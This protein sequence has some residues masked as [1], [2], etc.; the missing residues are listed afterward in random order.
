MPFSP[1]VHSRFLTTARLN[2]CLA[3]QGS[4]VCLVSYRK[5]KVGHSSTQLCRASV[6]QRWM[7]GGRLSGRY[8]CL[9]PGKV[10]SKRKGLGGR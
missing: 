8:T 1:Q 3:V 9:P 2:T 4:R 5:G 7:E 10:R 6:F